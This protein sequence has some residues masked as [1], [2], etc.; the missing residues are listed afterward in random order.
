MIK[1]VTYIINTHG[2]YS[3]PLE[4]L[5]DSMSYVPK[6][7]IVVVVAESKVRDEILVLPNG[8]RMV[9]VPHNS[10]DYTGAISLFERPVET[11]PYVF[12]LQDTMEF[13][14]NTDY[15]VRKIPIE[16]D[17]IAA[18]GGQCNLALYKRSY[19]ESKKDFILARKDMT[20]L[21][22]IMYE[23]TLWKIAD[24]KVS[25][26]NSTMEVQG[27]GNPYGGAERI[28]EYYAAIDLIKWKAN[29]GQN[30]NNLILHP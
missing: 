21:E 25:Y 9:H 5:L 29:Y 15:F 30:M 6:H 14:M 16:A 20:K 11:E 22:S 27:S 28:K 13:G 24:H 1:D 19:L 18:F 8:I 7:R 3:I 12:F 4:R 23:G 26:H 17:A 10:F 2:K